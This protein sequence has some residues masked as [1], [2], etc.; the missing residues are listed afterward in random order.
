MAI[1]TAAVDRNSSN[2]K[3]VNTLQLFKT[4][5]HDRVCVIVSIMKLIK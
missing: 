3:G 4:E 2:Y 5:V 1:K